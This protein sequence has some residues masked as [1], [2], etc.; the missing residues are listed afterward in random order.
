[1]KFALYVCVPDLTD[2]M[3]TT[4]IRILCTTLALTPRVEQSTYE[5]NWIVKRIVS[6]RCA[7]LLL[8]MVIFDAVLSDL[9]VHLRQLCNCIYMLVSY[10]VAR[11]AF[12][13]I[14]CSFLYESV[15]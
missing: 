15:L 5:I 3:L 13:T 9:L 14:L 6:F 8:I 12:F 11:V 4:R 1:M 10:G 2:I 7:F